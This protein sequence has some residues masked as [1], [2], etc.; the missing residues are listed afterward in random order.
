MNVDKLGSL[1]FS[2]EHDLDRELFT[3]LASCSH[4]IRCMTGYFT[5]SVLSELAHSLICF[6]TH[7][8]GNIQFIISPNLSEQ[9]LNAIGKSV[10]LN[11][12]F[13]HILFPDFELTEN[14]LKFKALN[15]LSYLIAT[16]R[17]TLK[18]ALQDTGM[19]HTKCW[20]FDLD[21]GVVAVHGSINATQSGIARNFEQIAV[22]KSWESDNSKG[23]VDKIDLTFQNIWEGNYEGLKTIPLNKACVNYLL[24]KYEDLEKSE[25]IQHSLM[26]GLLDITASGSSLTGSVQCLTVPTWLNYTS[27][28]FAHQG[29]A[30]DAWIGNEGQGILAIATGGGKT[31]TALVAASLMVAKEESLFIV[32]AVPTIALLNQWAD[33]VKAFGVEPLKTQGEQLGPQMNYGLRRLRL[34]SA[35]CE[36]MIVTHESLKS[37]KM[38]RL[39]DKA[40]KSTSLM[41][42]GDE[43]H[44]LGSIGFQSVAP[45]VFKY[46]LGLSATFQRQF[47]EEGTKFLLD[48]FGSVVFDFG[49]DEAIGV[50]LVPF[51]YFVHIVTLDEYEEEEWAELT[52][53]IKKLSYAAELANGSHEKE[54]WQALCIKRRRVVESASAKISVLASIFSRMELNKALVFCTDKDPKQLNQVNA[55]LNNKRINFHQIT[56]EETANK[57]KLAGLIKSFDSGELKVLTSKRVLDEGFNIPQTETA[58]LLASNTVKRQWVQ[59]LGRVLRQSLKTHKQKAIIHDFV[60]MPS[61][62]SEGID[63]DLK[64]LIKSELQRIQFFDSLCQNGL[65]RN[66]TA[67]VVEQLLELLEV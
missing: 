51:D 57:K 10:E 3:P 29:K 54:L 40:Q 41:L 64:G 35:K 9:D 39:L 63:L 50:C 24:K 21:Q 52:F 53:K 23:V 4:K 60:V 65:E 18:I 19:F 48:Y 6:L 28:D 14:A 47:D 13:I 46:R 66:G 34:K 38:L 32:I 62:S 16:K 67:D 55:L 27:G 56:A 44:N 31:L 61:V 37:A 43:V 11:E 42:I 1:Y 20:L 7:T 33:D 30:I 59:R 15:A 26:R 58:F 22:N 45:D 5:S 8:E 2:R 36:V 49:L 17:L 25:D 12:S